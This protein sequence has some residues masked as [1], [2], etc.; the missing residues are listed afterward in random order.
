MEKILVLGATGN[1][2][3]SV[4]QTLTEHGV[5]V[6]AGVSNPEKSKAL[7][8]D[9][10]LV[11]VMHFDFLDSSTFPDTLEGVTK[12]FFV[13]PPQLSTPKEDMFPFL[14]FFKSAIYRSCAIRLFNWRR[15]KS[16]H[17]SS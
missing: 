2:G 7:W 12:V 9:N 8:E 13:R 1:I 4:V 6:R 11:D 14:H 3:F 17:A 15:E 5:A 10:S 16:S